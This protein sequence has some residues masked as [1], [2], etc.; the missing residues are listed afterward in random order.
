MD[1][2]KLVACAASVLSLVALGGCQQV[3]WLSPQPMA[4][5]R[6]P[7][8]AEGE[9]IGTDGVAVSSLHDGQFQSRSMQTGEMLTGGSYSYQDPRTISL[10]FYSVKNKRRTTAT[11]LLVDPD[12]MNCTLASGTR[13]VLDR[14]HA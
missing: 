13:F 14:R 6:Q 10:T 9:W 7:R 1:T 3:G 2:F 11:C 5:S 8:G 4:V 12:Q